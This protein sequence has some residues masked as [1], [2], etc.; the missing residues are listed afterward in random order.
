MFHELMFDAESMF[1]PN[2]SVEDFLP[3]LSVI[4]F[5]YIVSCVAFTLLN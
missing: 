5:G 4:V 1:E 2:L 3:I